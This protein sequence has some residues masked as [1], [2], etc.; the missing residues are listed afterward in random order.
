[1]HVAAVMVGCPPCSE[2][3]EFGFGHAVGDGEGEAQVVAHGFDFVE[4]SDGR[5]DD[6][7]AEG[8]EFVDFFL[9]A[10]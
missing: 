6:F 1:M 8:F 10:T 3:F 9:V 2:W 7:R 4:G 5:G